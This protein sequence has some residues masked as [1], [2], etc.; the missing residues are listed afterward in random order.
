MRGNYPA[1]NGEFPPGRPG[2]DDDGLNRALVAGLLLETIVEAAG[3]PVEPSARRRVLK[4]SL[5]ATL[6]S[7]LSGRITLDRFRTL[8]REL[9]RCFALYY[10]LLSP[11]MSPPKLPSCGA[12]PLPEDEAAPRFCPAVRQDLLKMHL[13]RLKGFLPHRPHRKVDREGLRQFLSRTR[14]SWFR[15]K[16]F[17]QHFRIDRKTAW[18]YLQKLLEGGLLGHNQGRSAAV[19]YCLAPELLT[20]KA[21]ALRRAAAAA[22]AGLPPALIAQVA[23][24][25]IAT[26]GEPFWEEEWLERFESS[27]RP[28]LL[29][30]LQVCS[31]LEVRG[32]TGLSRMLA[33]PRKWLQPADP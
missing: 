2:L 13:E 31:L 6:V 15:L 8:V 1:L 27:R 5:K 16:D 30:R 33:L 11:A 10:P 20:V 19:R 18:E 17:E 4:A 24:W 21:Q 14:G 32:Q 29:A 12:T 28:D 3:L 25:L 23:D 7:R 9:D 26:G 22:L